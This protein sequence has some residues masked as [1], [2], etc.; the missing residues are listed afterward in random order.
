VKK[1]TEL[2]THADIKTRF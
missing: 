1:I 2:Q